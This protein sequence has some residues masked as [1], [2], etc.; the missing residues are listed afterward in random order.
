MRY[1]DTDF[2]DTW[3]ALEDAVSS[4]KIRSIGVSNFNCKQIQR[5][6][7]EGRIHP[8]NVQVKVLLFLSG[9][10]SCVFGVYI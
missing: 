2:M 5:I 3:R 1:A 4:G 8:S 9:I 10:F 6:I 7:N